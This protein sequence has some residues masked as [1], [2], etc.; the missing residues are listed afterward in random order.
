M[1]FRHYLWIYIYR[2]KLYRSTSM[3][4]LL[5][6]FIQL[7]ILLSDKYIIHIF[8][9]LKCTDQLQWTVSFFCFIQLCIF[10][11]DKYKLYFYEHTFIGWK[12]YK[13]TSMGSL[14][15]IFINFKCDFKA[16]NVLWLY[17]IFNSDVCIQSGLLVCLFLLYTSNCQLRYVRI[18]L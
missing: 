15:F 12:L 1:T 18:V 11:S 14:L 10:L 17:I 6:C 5:F 8:I 7:C 2:V 13:S 9:E 3:D 16:N 4:S